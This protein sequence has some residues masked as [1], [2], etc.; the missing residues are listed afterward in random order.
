VVQS[1]GANPANN[2]AR[3]IAPSL[4]ASGEYEEIGFLKRPLL[5]VETVVSAPFSENTYIGHLDGSPEAI[6]VDPGMQPGDIIDYLD[7]QGLSPAAI[8][9]THG[10]SDHIAGNA[11]MKQRWPQVPLVIGRN[12][13]VKLT[14]PWQN[15]SAQFGVKL[16]SPP[17]DQ[18]LDDGQTYHAAGL[19][20]T[21]HE[22]PGHSSGHIV[23]ICRQVEPWVVFGGDVLFAGSIGRTD[24]PDGDF[25]QLA[26]GIWQ[27]L[28]TLPDNTQVLAGHGP[29]TTV[30][31]ERRNNPYVGEKT[32]FGR[33]AK[34]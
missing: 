24:F 9:L 12:D 28:F 19:E 20:F 14:D 31:E 3:H 8:L 26:S 6:V 7:E 34:R 29:P 10:H 33:A 15:L 21:V 1:R 11:A 5:H 17:A 25:E 18:L 13:A 2:Y 22:I 30:G 32:P 27:H 4:P 23:F 16:I